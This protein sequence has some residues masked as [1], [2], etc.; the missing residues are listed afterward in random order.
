VVEDEDT[1]SR[2]LYK[3]PVSAHMR[4][5]LH[6]VRVDVLSLVYLQV[7]LAVMYQGDQG[8]ESIWGVA[9]RRSDVSCDNKRI[10][11]KRS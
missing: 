8:V 4:R 6:Q 10:G 1:T 9:G 7:G 3:R 5:R 2:I 11:T